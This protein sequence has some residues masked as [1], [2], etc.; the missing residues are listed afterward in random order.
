MQT[1][2]EDTANYETNKNKDAVICT[3]VLP[4]TLSMVVFF[5]FLIFRKMNGLSKFSGS[6]LQINDMKINNVVLHIK[7]TFGSW[8]NIK[9]INEF[10]VGVLHV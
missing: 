3:S 10:K 1:K 5:F 2:I 4:T 9:N 8:N 6:I 7:T